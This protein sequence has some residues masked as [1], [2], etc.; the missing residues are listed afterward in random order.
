[1]QAKREQ[2]IELAG[3]HGQTVAEHRYVLLLELRA[4]GSRGAVLVADHTAQ[5]GACRCE[6]S[7]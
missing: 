5:A 4:A 1:M 3:C 2:S 7:I 6:V